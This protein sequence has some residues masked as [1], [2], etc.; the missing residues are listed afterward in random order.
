[1]LRSLIQASF[2]IIVVVLLSWN[3]TGLAAQF[4][5]L[6]AST[7]FLQTTS[8]DVQGGAY[9]P[10]SDKV[11]FREYRQTI[12][13]SDGHKALVVLYVDSQDQ[14]ISVKRVE[15]A[16]RPQWQP[17]VYY[18]HVA[19]GLTAFSVLDDG[20]IKLTQWRKHHSQSFKSLMTKIFDT[21]S[22]WI[23]SEQQFTQ[24]SL[25]QGFD[26]QYSD[27]RLDSQS[28]I[29]AG[30]DLWVTNQWQRLIS[31]DAMEIRAVAVDA[32]Q[33]VPFTIAAYENSEGQDHHSVCRFT[34]QLAWWSLSWIL[35][36]VLL[37]YD[38]ASKRLL[39]YQGVTNLKDHNNKRITAD[40]HYEYR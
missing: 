32:Q 27:L 20:V 13:L 26:R 10:G 24:S 11:L 5:L 6:Q 35:S 29:D 16:N 7:S 14:L 38:C 40:I 2:S 25:G 4:S 34:M 1:M 19:S 3:V 30:F 22:N 21:R 9:Q 33:D 8:W 28:V 23:I 15:F 36:P 17:N 31:D 18:H 37:D 12:E 39:R